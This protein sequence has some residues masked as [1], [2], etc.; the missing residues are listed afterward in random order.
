MQHELGD[1][2]TNH[3]QDSEQ[4][5]VP[6]DEDNLEQATVEGDEAIKDPWDPTKSKFDTRMMTIDL[7]KRRIGEAEID[8]APD[9]QRRADLW[10]SAQK[11]RLIESLLVRIPLPAFYFD[12]T[13]E[14]R[15]LVVD[16]LQRLTVF[17]QFLLGDMRLENLEFLTQYDGRSFQELPRALQRRIE[18]TQVTVHLIQPGTQPEV[19]FHI[20]RRINTGGLVLT[21]QEIRHAL[22]QGPATTT[23]AEAARE[24]AF[25]HATGSSVKPHRMADRDLVLRFLAFYIS[26]HSAYVVP[27]IDAFLNTQMAKLNKLGDDELV[28]LKAVF[29]DVMKT[30]HSIFRQH[31]FR[32]QYML[33]QARKN[34]I[35]KALFEAWSVGIGRLSPDERRLLVQRRDAVVKKSI[36]LLGDRDFEKAVSVGTQDVSK[37]RKR[38]ENVE[39]ALK[40]VLSEAAENAELG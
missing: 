3:S 27:D 6:A 28:R 19:K 40:D 5:S 8:M 30:A 23:L 26:P 25:L 17:K 16:G 39:R 2:S 24:E 12:A 31:T 20:F 9:F 22:N 35:N 10:T 36:E 7:L 37:V 18:E 34:P 15:W 29:I 21:A 4:G 13:S 1:N 33:N 32:K 14:S 38:F 11:S